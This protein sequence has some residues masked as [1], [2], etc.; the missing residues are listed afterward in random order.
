MKFHHIGIIVNDLNQGIKFIKETSSIIKI[1]EI[2]NDKNIGVKIKFLTDKDGL[3]IELISPY[4]KKS[5]IKNLLNKRNS[6]IN[7]LA[8]K[9]KNLDFN[10]EKFKK[11]K[12]LQITN[13]IAAKA[14]N[15]KRVV[16]FITPL[17][18]II[19][20]IES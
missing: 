8:Y 11:K 12:C 17:Q 14:F 2:I 6:I 20:L 18:Y 1:S 5:P 15:G 3:L 10:I 13:P 9:V 4:G 7:H 16:F 19:E